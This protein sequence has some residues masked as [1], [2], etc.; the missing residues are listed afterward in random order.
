[1]ASSLFQALSLSH[2]CRSSSTIIVQTV[3][4]HK[5]RG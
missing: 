2:H 4:V 3:I 1:M 5:H